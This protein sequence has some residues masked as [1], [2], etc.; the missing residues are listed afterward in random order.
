[1]TDWEH[2]EDCGDGGIWDE[3]MERPAMILDLDVGV[4]LLRSVLEDPQGVVIWNCWVSSLYHRG[5]ILPSGH[6][7]DPDPVLMVG[8]DFSRGDLS[9]LRMDGIDLAWAWLEGTDFTGTS[10]KNARIGFCPHAIFRGSDLTGAELCGDI[11]TADFSGALV[12]GVHIGFCCSHDIG[13]PPAGLPPEL[14]S[15]CR[16]DRDDP[17]EAA[18]TPVGR[19]VG[20]RGRVIISQGRRPT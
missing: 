10:L 11:G 13:S 16:K 20:V 7:G 12:G 2:V 19:P 17:T 6:D 5:L 8:L 15:R 9:G 3:A 1:M 4:D 14:L 18:N